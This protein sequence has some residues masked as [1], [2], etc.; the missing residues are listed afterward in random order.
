MRAGAE[1][2]WWWLALTVGYLLLVTSPAGLE[3]PVG[4]VIGALAASL[5]VAARRAFAPP[6]TVPGFVRRV[7]LLP[8]DVAADAVS[9]TRLLVTGRAFGADC[10]TLDEIELMDDAAV[11]VWAVLLTSAA[12]GSLAADVEERDGGLVLRRHLLT[13]HHRA[14]A[15]LGQS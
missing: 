2:A 12:P 11:R 4:L 8:V 9:L 13:R 6:A 15:G 7:V 3:V 10:G 14:T 5:A 1:F